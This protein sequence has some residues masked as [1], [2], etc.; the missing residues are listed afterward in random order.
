MKNKKFTGT[1]AA[2]IL[3][4][5]AGVLMTGCDDED[6]EI[7]EPSSIAEITSEVTEAETAAVQAETQDVTAAAEFDLSKADSFEVTSESITD[8]VWNQIVS[9]T[10]KG[11][12]KSPQLAWDAVDGAE[13]YAIYMVDLT[14]NY[15]MHWK[16]ANVTETTLA[17][18]WA[19]EK[20]YVGPYPPSGPHKYNVYVFALKNSPE[21]LTGTFDDENSNWD[22]IVASLDI[23]DGES[24]NIISYG[25]IS[26]EYTP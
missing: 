16:S 13:G 3:C 5:T 23:A 4:M 8:G 19:D 2:V 7:N 12:N 21:E 26:G 9:N 20:E 14:A 22:E 6:F 18:G 15:W 25:M 10:Q 24:G 11:E 17:E 1:L